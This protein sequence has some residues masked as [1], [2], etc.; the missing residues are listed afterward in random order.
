MLVSERAKAHGVS[1]EVCGS[2]GHHITLFSDTGKY[3]CI[4]CGLYL[5]EIRDSEGEVKNALRAK[6]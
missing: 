6:A 4:Q 2:K 1:V 3:L 5:D